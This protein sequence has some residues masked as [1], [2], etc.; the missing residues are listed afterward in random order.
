MF[1][2][3]GLS[4]FSKEESITF[5]G[6]GG[7]DFMQSVELLAPAK[8]LESGKAAINYGADAVYIGADRFG[9]RA[10]AG[11]SI[12]DIAELVRY[13]H[14]Y[15]ANV[16]VTLNT[17]LYD[18]ELEEAEKLIHQIYEA[19]A[20]ALIIQDLGILMM[21]LPPIALH[22]STQTNNF[23]TERIKFIDSLGF[24]RIVLARE[25]KLPEIREIRKQTRAELEFF[26]H[27]AL[28]VSLSGQCYFSQTITGRSANRGMCSQMCR[29]PYHLID[30]NGQQ[31]ALNT[32][33]LSLKDLNNSDNLNDLLE[34][35]ITSLKIEG[36]LKD[37][38][39]V[40]N[41]VSYYRQKL[42][43]ILA[44][45]ARFS[46]ASAGTTQ[47]SFLPD[48][49]RSFNRRS[50]DYFLQDR[51]RE[52]INPATPKSIGKEIGPIIALQGNQVQVESEE[53]LSNGDGLCYIVDNQ[54]IGFRADKVTGDWIEVSSTAGLEV[55]MIL[56]RNYD[57][58]FTRQV[59]ND[60]AIRKMKVDIRIWEDDKG[61]VLALLDED[62]LETEIRIDN[63]PEVAR[64]YQLF[65]K[66]I[67]QQFAKDGASVFAVQSVDIQCKQGYFF[68]M[69]ALNELRRQLFEAHEEKRIQA[70]AAR[71][72]VRTEQP[73][74]FPAQTVDFREN[75]SNHKAE[76]FYKMHGVEITQKAIEVKKSR[77][78]QLLMTT[79][80][81]L[82]YELGGCPHHQKGGVQ[83]IEPLY[84]ED[85]NRKYRLHFDCRQCLM[86]IR[87]G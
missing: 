49:E 31:I 76:A 46:R 48:P 79:R 11:N 6:K 53:T 21:D 61:L 16:Y 69:A 78:D 34:A 68:R 37:I 72:F 63:L 1:S 43:A 87:L 45:N 73:L 57:H 62:G 81:C 75:I 74:S 23:N 64:D 14:L 60:A 27:G 2:S 41:V 44:G 58:Q 4:S 52:M 33:L 7:F 22:A 38:L 17:I 39:Y 8:N 15:R 19:G 26:I 55:G 18:S 12:Q 10:A 67:Q 70:F 32:H 30:G 35:G 36:R 80:Y 82:K 47:L 77:P 66:N 65:L 42:D 83:L 24:Q 54:L 5:D 9:A 40:K 50:T 86:E 56:Y 29:H 85:K 20:D 25:L 3:K 71:D 84:L 28:C 13:A 59:E 51:S